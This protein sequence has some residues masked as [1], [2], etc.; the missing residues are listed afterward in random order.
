M[1]FRRGDGTNGRPTTVLT[2]DWE[3]ARS[4]SAVVE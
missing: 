3:A 2:Q 1:K 4:G